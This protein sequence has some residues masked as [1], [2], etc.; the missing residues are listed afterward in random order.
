MIYW[1]FPV[2]L[3]SGECHK[4]PLTRVNIESDNGLVPLGNKPLSEPVLTNTSDD[5]WHH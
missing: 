4:I 1:A 3:F 2:K 5:I